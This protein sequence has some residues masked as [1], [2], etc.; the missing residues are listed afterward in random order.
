MLYD[1]KWEVEV[2]APVKELEPWQKKLTEV[3]TLLETR[4][5]CQHRM[6]GPHGSHCLVGAINFVTLG[7]ANNDFRAQFNEINKQIREKIRARIDSNMITWWNDF[8]ARTQ[9]DVIDMLQSLIKS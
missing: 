4:G 3:I 1:P 2:E 5:W 8:H 7:N 9:D 6:E